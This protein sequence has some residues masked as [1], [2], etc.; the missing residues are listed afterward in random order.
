MSRIFMLSPGPDAWQQFLA[1]PD[2]QWQTGYSA[3]TMAHSWEA[4]EGLPAEIARLF[5]STPAFGNNDPE[6][7]LA[8]PEHKVPLPGGSRESQNDVFALVR[9]G[10]R[11]LSVAVEGKVDEPFGPTIGDWFANPSDGKRE[12]MAFLCET[13]GLTEPIPDDIHYQ[14]LHRTASAVIEAQRFKTDCAAMVVHSFSQ[15]RMWVDAF[16]KFVGL[17]GHQVEVGQLVEVELPSGM[18]L[19]LGWACGDPGFLKA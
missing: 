12:R 2:K 15:T 17:Y 8:I 10:D 1:D 13:L 7:L 14:L 19:F 11:T 6:L 4:A 5:V 9:A 3:R 16:A 18:P